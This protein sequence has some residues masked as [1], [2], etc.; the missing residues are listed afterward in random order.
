MGKEANFH[1]YV[2][3]KTRHTEKNEKLSCG[4]NIRQKKLKMWPKHMVLNGLMCLKIDTVFGWLYRF[5][6]R[7]DMIL[8]GIFSK[9]I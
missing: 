4:F 7:F 5:D 3:I 2:H 6:I 9:K 8:N 1:V